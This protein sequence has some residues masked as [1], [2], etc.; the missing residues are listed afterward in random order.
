MCEEGKYHIPFPSDKGKYA[1]AGL[2]PSKRLATCTRCPRQK[3][4]TLRSCQTAMLW[5]VYRNP[6]R[7]SEAGGTLLKSFF[8]LQE[9]LLW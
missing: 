6:T 8:W 7:S 4:E 9:A 2:D 3:T 1:A 5:E